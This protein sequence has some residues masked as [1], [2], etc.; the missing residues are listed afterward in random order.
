MERGAA[1]LGIPLMGIAALTG[2]IDKALSDSRLP[3]AYVKVCL[4]SGGGF[5]Y[6]DYPASGDIIIIV[7]DYRPRGE[8]VRA[9]IC[10]FKRH[11]GSPIRRIKSLNYLEN[12]VARREANRTGYNESAI[13]NEKGEITEC[14]SSNI[15][16]VGKDTLCTPSLD[17]GLLAGVTREILINSA[18]ELGLTVEEGGYYPEDL[19]GS[20]FAFLTNSLSGSLLISELGG[21]SLPLG[22]EL[23]ESIKKLLYA[24]LGWDQ[25]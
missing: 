22:D 13:L 24:K 20:R 8:P 1:L 14:T 23:Y 3:D 6:Y 11:S 9:D 16:W 25:N 5:N 19:A 2:L 12:V 10:S 15:F 21:L 7:R 4:L 18:P 17:C